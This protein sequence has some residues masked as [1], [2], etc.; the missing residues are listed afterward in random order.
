MTSFVHNAEDRNVVIVHLGQEIT[1]IDT[2]LNFKNSL[3]VNS[4]V[5]LCYAM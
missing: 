4:D 5:I 1:Q 2:R 3:S